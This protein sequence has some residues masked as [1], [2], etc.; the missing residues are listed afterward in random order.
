MLG[1]IKELVGNKSKRTL[2]LDALF[3][4]R[5][6]SDQKW[7][8]IALLLPSFPPGLDSITVDS[9]LGQR[10]V[11]VRNESKK[12]LSIWSRCCCDQNDQILRSSSRLHSPTPRLWQFRRIQAIYRNGFCIK[13]LTPWLGLLFWHG[14]WGVFLSFFPPAYA[15]FL[16][17]L[18]LQATN[19]PN[20]CTV[21]TP[22]WPYCID[23][24]KIWMDYD[25][26]KAVKNM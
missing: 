21:I 7:P 1:Q 24:V 2:Y 10:K 20:W 11:L 9:I 18:A 19:K 8:N 26:P 15:N 14:K 5:C 4:T 25:L 3:P 22:F 17:E 12:T 13:P 23:I 16:S 6:C